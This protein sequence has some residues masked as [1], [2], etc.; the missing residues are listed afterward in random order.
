M[1]DN[2][3]SALEFAMQKHK[4]QLDKGWTPYIQHIMGVWSRVRDEDLTTQIAALL[5]DT[6]E[7]TNTTFGELIKEFG[8]SVAETVSVLTHM[9]GEPY[10][11]Y[12]YRIATSGDIRAIKIKLADL[13]D[14]SSPVRLQRLPAERRAYFEKRIVEKYQK[15]QLTLI[16]A[17]NNMI[18]AA[19][20]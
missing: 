14:N 3:E 12:I 11:A 10:E 2:F 1:K 5:H 19:R 13:E 15:A 17:L 18:G 20:R 6:V 9:K 8:D 4:G 7:D 16:I